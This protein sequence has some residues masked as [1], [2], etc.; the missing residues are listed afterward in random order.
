MEE[1]RMKWNGMEYNIIECEG[2]GR[3]GK[4][5]EAK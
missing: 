2:K 5:S 3:E 1:K 4:E